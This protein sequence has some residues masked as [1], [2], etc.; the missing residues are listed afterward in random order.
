[1]NYNKVSL[2]LNAIIFYLPFLLNFLKKKKIFFNGRIHGIRKVPG[3]T[4]NPHHNWDLHHRW[5][6]GSNS[7]LCSNLN[8]WSQ[9]LN[10]L[11][12]S[13]APWMYVLYLSVCLSVCLCRLFRAAPA[14]YGSSQ[15]RGW[16]GTPA[17]SLHHSHS[18]A[19]LELN[20]PSTPQ[21]MAVP[22]P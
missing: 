21:L 15:A 9:I 11:C 1:M 2:F 14:A 20:L 17:A 18:N 7:H 13:R 8:H 10:P 16:I 19:R 12:H 6:W 4:L 5:V 22:D 3:Q